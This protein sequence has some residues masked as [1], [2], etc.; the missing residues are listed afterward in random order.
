LNN[1]P[2][3]AQG[4]SISVGTGGAGDYQSSTGLTTEVG[5]TGGSSSFYVSGTTYGLV[6]GGGGGS[7]DAGGPLTTTGSNGGGSGANYGPTNRAG[8]SIN[9]AGYTIAAGVS[10][11]FYGGFQGDNGV[12]NHLAGGGAGAGEAGGTN[13]QSWGG[14]GKQISWATRYALTGAGD[15]STGLYFGGGGGGCQYGSSGPYGNHPAG[16]GGGGGASNTNGTTSVGGAGLNAGGDGQTN[17]DTG[18]GFN[19]ANGGANTGGGGGGGAHNG[20]TGGSGGSGI[21][22]VRYV[23]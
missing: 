2:V 6:Q 3:T 23:I 12:S 1:L 10:A 17:T 15:A 5:A 9:S 11:D 4:Y 19:G 18:N 8:N 13:G 16:I 21:V 7:S 20:S 14:D 22:V